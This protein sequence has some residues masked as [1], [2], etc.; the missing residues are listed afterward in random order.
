MGYVISGTDG[1]DGVYLDVRDQDTTDANDVDYFLDTPLQTTTNASGMTTQRSAWTTTAWKHKAS[2][3]ALPLTA[4]RLFRPASSSTTTAGYIKH[5]PLWYA[6]KWGG[7]ADAN[8]NGLPDGLEWDS[9]SDGVPDNYFLVTNAG[10]LKEQLSKAFQ[11]ILSKRASAAIV[12]VFTSGEAWGKG[13]LYLARF[14]ST[15]WT[16]QVLAIKSPYRLPNDLV[17]DAGEE[18]DK[19][20]WTDRNVFTYNPTTKK[21]VPFLWGSLSTSQQ[22]LLSPKKADGTYDLAIGQ[23]RLQFLRGDNSNEGDAVGKFRKRDTDKADSSG[24]LGSDLG[25]IINSNPVYLAYP[26]GDYL[27]SL[28]TP[29]YLSFQVAKADRLGMVY[30]GANDGMLHGFRASDGYETMAYVPTMVYPELGRLTWQSYNTTTGG[31]NSGEPQTSQHHYYV[32]STPSVDDAFFNGAWHTVLIGRLGAGGQGT[33]ALDVTDPTTFTA[34]N[35]LWEFTDANDAD[36]GYTFGRADI[37]KTNAGI[38]AAVFGNGYNSAQADNYIGSGQ[39]VL[40]LVDVKT[41]LLIKKLAAGTNSGGL[42]TPWL[43][44]VDGDG[45]VDWIYAGDVLGNLWKFDVRSKNSGDWQAKLLFAAGGTQPITSSPQTVKHPRGGVLV[46][47]GTGRYLGNTDIIDTSQQT[48]YAIWDREDSGSD[49]KWDT[50]DDVPFST[51]TGLNNLLQQSF[52][53]YVVVN[54]KTWRTSSV[55]EICWYDEENLTNTDQYCQFTCTEETLT[56]TTGCDTAVGRKNK[57]DNYAIPPKFLGWYINLPYQGER[58]YSDSTVSEGRILF[59]SNAPTS[60]DDT[61]PD[62]CEVKVSTG[63]YWVN[64]LD[65]LTGK[66]L[67]QSYVKVDEEG[68]VTPVQVTDSLT[69]QTVAPSSVEGDGVSAGQNLIRRTNPDDPLVLCS[70]PECEDPL[71]ITSSRL[72]WRQLPLPTSK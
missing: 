4:T 10:K 70:G 41:G 16:G 6:A 67:G 52:Q 9:D 55:K 3:G 7:F 61:S 50:T 22:Q 60:T 44:D 62:P 34:D 36:L 43:Y 29:T 53:S 48:Y 42:S 47:F 17:W 2:Y 64:V 13:Y 28:E 57:G 69:G 63:K 66:R 18:L 45:K 19:R 39:G 1:Q 23:Q 56:D 31:G 68:N 15:N 12:P 11:A 49:G 37:A 59:T 24:A 51:V 30:V 33:F 46:L 38:W 71:S 65:A 54:G 25:D 5:D 35:F 21:A 58:V 8:K 20:T 27:D 14:N 40:Y 32:D 72:S 26:T